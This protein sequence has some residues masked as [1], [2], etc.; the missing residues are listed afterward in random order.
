MTLS[1]WL[2][3]YLYITLGG[4]RCSPARRRLNLMI[5]MILGGLWHGANWT[6][7]AWGT[8]HGLLLVA[9]HSLP[10]WQRLGTSTQRNLTF[11]LVTVGWVFF[12]AESFSH[13]GQWLGSLVGWHGITGAWT[14]GTLWL[15]GLV[16]ACLVI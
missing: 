11:F 4:N 1:L 8:W 5:T 12:R 7:A 16:L 9:H 3:D 6:F 15:L 14:L 2:R 10:A 13:A